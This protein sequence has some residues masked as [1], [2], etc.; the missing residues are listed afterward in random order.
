MADADVGA[1]AT[2]VPGHRS[3][4][5][6]VG[7]RRGLFEQGG[8]ADT[9]NSLSALRSMRTYT[10]KYSNFDMYAVPPGNVKQIKARGAMDLDALINLRISEIIAQK[11][12]IE[13]RWF[14]AQMHTRN[15]TPWLVRN[16]LGLPISDDQ[17]KMYNAKHSS[18]FRS[19]QVSDCS[20]TTSRAKFETVFETMYS[21]FAAKHAAFFADID[22]KIDKNVL[23][24]RA[25][26]FADNDAGVV[27]YLKSLME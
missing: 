25:I 26:C 13:T 22:A 10:D 7:R 14:Y 17:I 2:D 24:F 1:A 5:V 9:Y 19:P 8:G 3:I 4:D 16:A 27:E 21:G 11:E 12:A 23:L 6:G 15:V 20:C 18:Y